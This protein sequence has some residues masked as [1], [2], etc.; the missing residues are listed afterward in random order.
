MT[1]KYKKITVKTC[2]EFSRAIQQGY[3]FNSILLKKEEKE[4]LYKAH[5]GKTDA[6]SL[7][8]LSQC[9]FEGIGCV[10]DYNEY[11]KITLQLVAL[12]D[13]RGYNCLG[14]AL[15]HGY[16]VK[17][18]KKKAFK[19]FVKAMKKGYAL[20]TYN[21]G[22]EYY[23]HRK[24]TKRSMKLVEKYYTQAADLGFAKAQF[25]IGALYI[26]GNKYIAPNPKRAF[27]YTSLASNQG[28]EKAS[29]NMGYMFHNGFGVERD[30]NK[31]LLY[32]Q[33]AAKS[34][35]AKA[36]FWAGY[37]IENGYG[38]RKDYGDAYRYYEMGALL[39]DD[40]C[41]YH[42]GLMC[43]FGRGVDV[44]VPTAYHYLTIAKA[45]KAKKV[46][47]FN[48]ENK[49]NCSITSV[50]LAMKYKKLRYD[51]IKVKKCLEFYKAIQDGYL[52]E[53]IDIPVEEKNKLYKTFLHHEDEDALYIKIYC[54]K[55][56]YGVQVNYHNELE[57][58]KKLYR[59][60]DV[61]S[62]GCLGNVYERLANSDK[63]LYKKSFDYYARGASVGYAYCQF[64]IAYT[65]YYGIGGITPHKEKGVEYFKKASSKGYI[66]ADYM[67]GKIYLEDKDFRDYRLA[68]YYL[69][70][71][72]R[73]DCAGALACLSYMY[74]NNKGVKKDG[75]KAI[76]L[77]ERAVA[78]NPNDY[79]PQY[80]LGYYYYNDEENRD[81]RK[82]FRHFYAAFELNH[83]N[84]QVAYF[85]G[86]MYLKGQGVNKD[87]FEGVRL[88]Q[89]S[90]DNN[91]ALA[92]RELSDC[93]YYGIGV[94]KDYNKATYY[95][96]LIE[97]Q[98]YRVEGIQVDIDI[99]IIVDEEI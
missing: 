13:V 83:N 89:F 35:S 6:D 72:G 46:K 15:F 88:L 9:L 24:K 59:K 11:Y 8:I 62:F 10:K 67:L 94:P 23:S 64:H 5:L 34:G 58:A 52:F 33:K 60:D 45:S 99:D 18:N 38:V 86:T 2:E 51:R 30:L 43:L 84:P 87:Q 37:F 39:E 14:Y 74:F 63:E 75:L 20:A 61:R 3:T 80:C 78:I 22:L 41:N 76:E 19:Y 49:V 68:L 48:I 25:A 36:C 16:G 21:V 91:F 53:Y 55:K 69:E 71:A 4:K 70:K 44:N 31:A 56:G 96:S 32:Y 12:K 40:D 97:E 77:A 54:L 90:A 73:E 92:Y 7:Y 95:R 17:T 47:D 57:L 82:A 28:Y 79:Y 27:Y 50:K 66:D 98:G 29:Y 81:Y 93:Y 65:F 1:Y 42:L 26:T 85:L